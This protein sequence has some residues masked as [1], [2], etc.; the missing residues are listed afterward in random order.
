MGKKRIKRK[1]KKLSIEDYER[2]SKARPLKKIRRAIGL[3]SVSLVNP[4]LE[5]CKKFFD[6][7]N[8]KDISITER[9]H[10]IERNKYRL[11]A[12]ILY[13]PMGG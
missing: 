5:Q 3:P 4:R 12:R 11:K 6:D 1:V 8:N 7:E 13:T 2:F 9:V 10:N